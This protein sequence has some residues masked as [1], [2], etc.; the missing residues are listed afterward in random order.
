MD[1]IHAQRTKLAN[2]FF[3][4]AKSADARNACYEELAAIHKYL[5]FNNIFKVKTAKGTAAKPQRTAEQKTKD[6]VEMINNLWPEAKKM[7][8]AEW[9]IEQTGEPHVDGPKVI[10]KNKKDRGILS[11][12]FLYAMVE[13]YKQ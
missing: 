1:A 7:A 9:P 13:N 4:K 3:D 2:I 6:S 5:G 8:L 11:Q 12:V 10:D